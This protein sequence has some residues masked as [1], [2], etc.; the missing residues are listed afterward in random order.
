MCWNHLNLNFSWY[1]MIIKLFIFSIGAIF[2]SFLNVC[3]YRLP[4]KKS[5]ISPGSAC[6]NCTIPIPFYYNIPI[7]SYLFLKGRC[8]NCTYKIPL[9]YLIVELFT[10]FITLFNY[11]QFDLSPAFYAY[12]ILTYALLVVAVIDI[13]THLIL[14][15]VLIVLLIFGLVLNISFPFTA[16]TDALWGMVAGGMSM[17]F[18]A[19]LGKLLFK[20]ESLGMGDVKL[21]AVVGFFV[22]WLHTLVAIYL[23]FLLAFI[24][25]MVT[26]RSKGINRDGYIP[27]GPF[28]SVAFM[29]FVYWGNSIL[30]YYIT[31]F[32]R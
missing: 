4:E 17:F 25:L 31:H 10:A 2:G 3:I 22:G 30:R 20:K 7:F 16:W 18:I 26:K 13:K 29:V 12:T 14:N 23:G 5:I 8:H 27:L 21:V 15:K 1:E 32:L 6:P 24:W 28:L 19:F 11:S 9:H